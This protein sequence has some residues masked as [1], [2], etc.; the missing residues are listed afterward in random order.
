MR[1]NFFWPW[2]M[3]EMHGFNLEAASL[4]H[5]VISCLRLVCQDQPRFSWSCCLPPRAAC[6]IILLFQMLYSSGN[7]S[8][9]LKLKHIQF[10]CT[11]AHFNVFIYTCNKYK[12][13]SEGVKS[14]HSCTH[15]FSQ[16]GSCYIHWKHCLSNNWLN[17]FMWW[18][19]AQLF[20]GTAMEQL[21][22]PASFY[23]TEHGQN[24]H[25]FFFTWQSELFEQ[26]QLF[27]AILMLLL[28]VYIRI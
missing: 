1:Q 17:R 2:A 21:V 10:L 5:K 8:I 16:H 19:D 20:S 28:A 14:T 12:A 18:S 13:R 26:V 22:A 15:L 3:P 6:G 27:C 24:T 9:L 11:S 23:M 25:F 4:K 7:W